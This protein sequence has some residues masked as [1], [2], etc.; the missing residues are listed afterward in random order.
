M[1]YT[2]GGSPSDVLTTPTGDVVPDYPVLVKVASTGQTITALFEAD[3]TTPI[4][5]LRSNPASH[6]Q[7]GAIRPFRIDGVTAIE[8]EY[9]DANGQPVR[10]YQAA[11]ELAQQAAAAAA[12]A[13]SRSSGGTVT[14]PVTAAAGLAVQQGLAVTGGATADELAVTGDLAVGGTFA[15]DRLSLAS[16]RIFN[17]RIYG[18]LGDGSHDDAPAFQAA[19]DAAATVGGGWVIIP[20]GDYLLATLPLRQLCP[21]RI[22]A[23]PGAYIRRGANQTLF[24]NGLPDQNYPGY[25][26]H[27]DLLLEG[28]VWDM[29][30]T[31]P[32]LTNSRMC[33]SLGH[34]QNITIRDL[35]VLDVPGFHAIE[36]NA[37]RTV[38]IE[39]C[40]FKGFTDPGGRDISEAIQ[41]DLMTEAG[42]FGGFG[43]YDSV[44]CEDVEIRGCYFGPSGTPGTTAWPRGIGS[45]NARI[46]RWQKD[47]RIIGNTFEDCAQYPIGGYNWTTVTIAGNTMR[48]CGAGPRL[49]TVDTARTAHTQTPEGVQTSASQPV[50][51][52]TIV[53][54]TIENC[55]G[56]DDAIVVEGEATG[57]VYDVTITGNTIDGN[58]DTENGIRLIYTSDYTVGTNPISNVSGSG[59]SQEQCT[60]GTVDGN[61][62]HAPTGSGVTAN[63]CS[64]VK[65][66]DNT[67]SEPGVQGVWLVGGSVLTVEDNT[68]TSPSRAAAGG[69]YGIRASSSASD[70]RIVGNTVRRHGSGNEMAYALSITSSCSGV[71]RWGNDFDAGTLGIIDD[72]S[73]G[74]ELSPFDALGNLEGLMRPAGRYETTSRLRC[75]TTSTPTSGTLYLVPLWLPKGAVIGNLTF[76]S[77]G[78]AAASPTNWWFSLHDSARKMLAR[79][80]DQLTAS[81]AANTVKTLS[82]AQT[83]A[84]AATTYTTTYSGLH[85]LGVMIRATT[86]CSLVS[87][88]AVADVLASVTPGFG[89]TDTGLTTPPTVSGTGF[90]AGA[91]GAGS[92]VL[93]YGYAS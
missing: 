53:G 12:D 92:G 50:R 16:M 59:I 13:L 57:R 27:G 42:A 24:L 23:M 62:V 44:A 18:A 73:P 60:G 47:I 52:I 38:R 26:G 87:E 72:Q 11:R 82:I 7:P 55:T 69:G 83:T 76:V 4:S 40:Q 10:W 17:P 41:I 21:L 20:P 43:P 58:T 48:N 63:A 31:A 51:N 19:F 78:T 34:A 25:T 66:T 67:I 85:Y 80:A 39:N 86:V 56:Y 9:L 35:E 5:Q 1:L 46:G 77:G 28:G 22:T 2:F 90:T 84:G 93:L 65:M 79:S 54:N 37:C 74:T 88:G 91:F 70:I 14:A 68:I 45:H 3:G 15:P 71:R 61:R 29:R 75:G 8:Y 49:R 33:F 89:G 81:W 32:G 6:P 36:V 64:R 30:A